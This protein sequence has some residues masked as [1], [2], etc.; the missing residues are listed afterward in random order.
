MHSRSKKICFFME[1]LAL[2]SRRTAR[3]GSKFKGSLCRVFNYMEETKGQGVERKLLFSCQTPEA[4]DA[5][6]NK[7]G[8]QPF[9][10]SLQKDKLDY[11]CPM[12]FMIP[13]I[14]AAPRRAFSSA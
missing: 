14:K 6:L 7:R 10:T 3:A 13:S 12:L 1:A 8:Q 5:T 9:A 4:H 11:G 2:P